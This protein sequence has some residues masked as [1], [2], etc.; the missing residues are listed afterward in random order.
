MKSIEKEMFGNFET[1]DKMLESKIPNSLV[2][3][4]VNLKCE[5]KRVAWWLVGMVERLVAFEKN[6]NK[7]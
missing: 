7:K 4:V 6:K 5:W 3:A 2:M 1:E